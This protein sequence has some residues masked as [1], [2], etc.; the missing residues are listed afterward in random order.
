MT[1]PTSRSGWQIGE[2]ATHDDPLL[3]ALV[4][5]TRI[6]GNP[7]T[8]EALSAGLPLVDHRLTPSL[9]PRAAARAQLTARIVRKPLAEITPNFLPALLLL[10]DRRACL[11]LERLPDGA[12]RVRFPEAG[13][14]VDVL[15]A[16]ELAARYTGL[17]CFVRPRFRFEARAPEI[18]SLRGQH[19]FWGTVLDN[20]RLYR[21]TLLAA[22]VIN[23]FALAIP[24]FS[25]T[26]Y[27][28]VVPNR[29]VETLWVLAV[30]TALLLCFDFAL[31]TL[32]AY[33]VDTAGKRIDVQLSARIMERVLGLRMEARPASVGSFAANLRAFEGVRDFIASATVT[34]LI[35]LPFV[36]L[37]LLAMAWISPWLMIPPVVGILVVL[38]V[39]LIAQDKMHALTET[40]YRAGA[41]RNATLVESLV[42]L[43]TLKTLAAEG[44]IQRQYERATLFIA[45]IG[46]RLKLLSAGT[47][48]F[49]QFM[50]QFVSVA[51]IIVGVYELADAKMSLGGI[52]A[53]SMLAGRT[54]APLGQV[55]GLLMQYHNARTALETVEGHMQLPVERPD[56]A[57]FVHRP[58]FRGEIEFKDVSFAY[59]GRD[60]AALHTISFRLQAGEKVAIIGRIGSGKT[61]IEKL[62][63]GL[64]QPTA[65]AVLIDGI[66]ARQVDPA[67]LRRAIG[68]VPQDV[69]LFYGSLKQN[70]AMGAPF[71]DDAAVLA[72]AELAGVKEFADAHPQGFDMPIGERGES[73]SGGQRQA[74][75][76]ARAVLNDPPILLLDEPSSS[77]DHQS[78]EQLKQR[79]RAFA[80]GKTIVLVTHRTSLLDLVDR[81]IVLDQGHIVA[82]GPK[83]QVVEALQQ[84]R[85][86]RGG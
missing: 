39:T 79:L 60:Q 58:A 72:A 70:I 62:I 41:Q 78:E 42:G 6:H 81:L 10:H 40:T 7:F 26:V 28:R 55:A 9:L 29:A 33:I 80:A 47:V 37:F 4:L 1:N 66:D 59:P 35:D 50:Q 14:S 73:L 68:F 45:Q 43:E 74:V 54:M 36:L 30:G 84:G 67:E 11:L 38:F 31:R 85:I 69:T 32:R 75:A 24:L 25:M 53:A 57:N 63:L 86:G 17:V 27:D 71:A 64:Y 49:A 21:D 13:E 44:L 34:T 15:S 3:D 12:C 65:G 52:I 46:G 48:N 5:L 76:I 8:P 82:D 2:H 23:L 19:W 83:A 56:G 20:W 77:M 61:T 16:D 51:V 18:R 22:L